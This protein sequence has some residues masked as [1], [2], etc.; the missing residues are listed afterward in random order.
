[1]VKSLKSNHFKTFEVQAVRKFVVV[2]LIVA[3][4]LLSFYVI[5]KSVFADFLVGNIEARDQ[6]RLYYSLFSIFLLGSYVAIGVSLYRQIF[7]PLPQVLRRI[8]DIKAH[9]KENELEDYFT[10]LPDFWNAIEEEVLAVAKTV[11]RRQK[12]VER[13][14]KTIERLLDAFPE[15]TLIVGIDSQINYMNKAFKVAFCASIDKEAENLYLHDVFREPDVLSMIQ[16][17]DANTI[18]R[19][20]QITLND[21]DT[22]KH[23][24]VYKTPFAT[25]LEDIA[26]EFMIIFHDISV[27]K[28]TDLM[29]ADFVSNVSHELRTPVMSIQGYVRTLRDDIA[30][31]RLDHI[32][33]F[34]DIIESHVQRLNLLIKDLLE[35]SF[36]ES[37]LELVKSNVETKSMTQKILNQFSIELGRGEYTV[38]ESYEADQVIGEPRL[39]EQI[40]INFIQ[41]ALR[42][43][44]PKSK[45]SITWRKALNGTEL[46]FKDNGPGVSEEHLNRLFERFY[47][48]DPHRSRA[49]GGTGLGLSIA[50][51]IMQRHDGTIRVFSDLGHGMKF[52]C[53]FPE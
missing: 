37:S 35:L 34:F 50:K 10:S 49:H 52:I 16:N 30:A 46:V 27:A 36:L 32:D 18:E 51:H 15:P 26:Q 7:L 38:D 31:N 41:N 24:I 13:I 5:L 11:G 22:T 48:V 21:S 9:Q 42:Y 45:I 2:F 1:M 47:R 12:H 29:K 8:Q 43:T 3:I 14:R 20:V 6:F 44:P 19:E 25:R 17:S 33:K 40:L 4:S 53:F 39:I 23:F 28:K